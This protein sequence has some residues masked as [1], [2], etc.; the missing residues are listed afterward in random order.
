MITVFQL[1]TKVEEM[2]DEQ[3]KYFKSRDILQLQKCKRIEKEVRTM[4]TA[5]KAQQNPKMPSLFYTPSNAELQLIET[6]TQFAN[7]VLNDPQKV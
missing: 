6:A 3:Q 2:L 5:V 4:L 1:A 7:D